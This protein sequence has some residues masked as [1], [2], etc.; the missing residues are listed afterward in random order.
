L[1]SFILRYYSADRF[2]DKWCKLDFQYKTNY[3]YTR[4]V[5]SQ[6]KDY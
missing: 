2:V 5:I 3:V 6:F 4:L 1:E